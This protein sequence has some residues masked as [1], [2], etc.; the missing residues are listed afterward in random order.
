MGCQSIDV[1]GRK[2]DNDEI[3]SVSS[4]DLPSSDP[5]IGADT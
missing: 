2:L 4:D 1:K 5:V 3:L